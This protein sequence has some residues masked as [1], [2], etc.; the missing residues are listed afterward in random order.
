MKTI[1]RIYPA[2]GIARLG[3]SQQAFFIGPEA[4]G[5]VPPSPYR[6]AE[7]KIKRQAA[8]FRIYAFERDEFGQEVCKREVVMTANIQIEWQVQLGNR[9]AMGDRFPPDG[10][11]APLRRNSNYDS[12]G[13]IILTQ[14]AKVSGKNQEGA[15]LSGEIN[16]I[17]NGNVESRTP[18]EL[19]LLKTDEKGRLIVLGGFGVSRSPLGSRLSNYA[20]NDGWYDDISDGPVRATLRIKNDAPIEAEPAWLVVAPP[21]YAPGIDNVVTWYDQAEN[22]NVTFFN[23]LLMMQRPS[24]THHIYP[25]L[26]RTVLLHWVLDEASRHHGAGGNFLDPTRLEQLQDN[27]NFPATENPRMA[28]FRRLVK[29]GTQAMQSEVFPQQPPDMPRLYSGLNP[30]N[31]TTAVFASL[32]AFQYTL[33][34]KWAQ[35]D[36]IA[37]WRGEPKMPEFKRIPIQQQPDALTRAALEACIG[38]PFFPGIECTYLAAQ[39]QTY[40]QPFRIQQG[41]PPGYLTE[42]MALPWQADFLACGELWW[43]AQRP[44]TVTTAAGELA[45]FSRGIQGFSGMVRWWQEL[46]FVV[47]TGAEFHESERGQIPV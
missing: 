30:A 27:S 21:A 35:G 39:P 26:K 1:F 31:P 17:R 25:I 2:I 32:T 36:F 8:R 42:R 24:F 29:P 7:G 38:G 46:G 40:E 44:V 18:V 23:P 14:A 43:P 19:G 9:K 15:P 13:L 6:D 45:A 34:E 5:I 28:L 22:V 3:N 10:G 16:F 11:S 4:P 47:Q 12:A 41:F 37:D 33:M 20:N